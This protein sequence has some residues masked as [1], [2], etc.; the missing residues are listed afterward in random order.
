[1]HLISGEISYENGSFQWRIR[2]AWKRL[3]DETHKHAEEKQEPESSISSEEEMAHETYEKERTIPERD[4]V[5]QNR[6]SEKPFAERKTE[7]GEKSG[8]Y[9]R[10]MKIPEKIKYTFRRIY[11]KIRAL[12]TK[13]DRI[14]AFLRSSTHQNAFSRLIKELK[15]LLYFLRPSD[16]S[17]DLEFGFSDPAHTG[18]TLAGI[19]MIYPMIGEFAQ[20]RPDFERKILKGTLYIKGKIRVLYGLIFAWNMFRDKNVR[21]TYRHI[22]KFRL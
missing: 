22:R 21:V 1:M 13:K 18:Y 2:A 17:G 15:R 10:F 16:V 5:K 4:S 9:E 14:A 20:I 19:S 11:D 8:L 6:V 7:N 12:R 3:T